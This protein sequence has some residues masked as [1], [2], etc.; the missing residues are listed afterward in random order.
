MYCQMLV[1]GCIFFSTFSIL[2]SYTHITNT[3]NSSVNRMMRIIDAFLLNI[4]HMKRY[5]AGMKILLC[6]CVFLKSGSTKAGQA[7]DK[8]RT[9]KC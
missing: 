9:S 5:C 2:L 8:N 3:I 1:T 6:G 7:A 4:Q